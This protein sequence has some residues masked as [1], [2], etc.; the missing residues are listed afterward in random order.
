[1]WAQTCPQTAL[2]L[3]K[4]DLVDCIAEQRADLHAEAL[5][6]VGRSSHVQTQCSLMQD[7]E[8]TLYNCS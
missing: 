1:M 5:L 8:G 6:P 7:D 2:T 4:A 3:Y